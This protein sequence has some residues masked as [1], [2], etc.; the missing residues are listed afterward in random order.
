MSIIIINDTHGTGYSDLFFKLQ[1]NK[2]NTVLLDTETSGVDPHTNRILLLQLG[3]GDDIYVIDVARVGIPSVTGIVKTL[4]SRKFRIVAHNAKFDIKFLKKETDVLLT[5]VHDTLTTEVLITAGIGKTLY[6]LAELVSKYCNVTLDKEVRNEFID[7][8]FGTVITNNQISYSATDVLYLNKI[9]ISQ[10]ETIKKECMEKVYDLEM[11][12]I[13]PVAMMEYT[14]ITPDRDRWIYLERIAL[15]RAIPFKEAVLKEIVDSVDYSTINNGLELADL[16]LIK[17]KTKRDRNALALITDPEAIKRWAMDNFNTASSDQI[18]NA[19]NLLGIKTESSNEKI[20]N[21]LAKCPVIDNLLA[22]RE[23][24]KLASTYGSN[25]SDLTNPVTGR[26]HTDYLNVGT[27]TGR[28]SSRNPNLQNIPADNEYRSGFIAALGYSFIN[29]DYSQ[30]EFRL[31]GAVSKEQVIIDAYLNGADMH[32]ATAALIYKKG[33]EDISGKERNFGKTLNF[34]ILY[35]TTEWGLKKNLNI[36]IDE[37]INI[38]KIFYAGYPTLSSFKK[39]AEDRI[40]ELGYSITPL[41]RRRYFDK[42]PIFATPKELERF[43]SQIRREGF[44]H[45]IQGGGADITK[46]ALAKMFY[47]NPF[48]DRFKIILQ[49][50]DEIGAEVEDSIIQDAIEYMKFSMESVFT[51]F[52]CGI[53]AKVEYKVGKVWKK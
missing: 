50:H 12:D 20:L 21:K 40:L 14:G 29:M 16:L 18:T 52:L 5:N 9:Y 13:A 25:I 47:N 37:A 6:S 48:G 4:L 15:A 45:I 49:V 23:Q 31:A 35:G 46:L 39:M 2:L 7:M 41:G 27:K 44:N 3:I 43:E 33:L 10:M 51:P 28:F 26:I 22:Y 11:R 36:S 53:P 1:S 24:Q 17:V 30:Q 34:A 38:I 42:R 8:E 32:T 19:L